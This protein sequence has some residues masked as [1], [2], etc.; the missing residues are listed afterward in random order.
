MAPPPTEPAGGRVVVLGVGEPYRRDDGCGPRVVRAVR[1]RVDASVTL[2]E[3]VADPTALLDLWDGAGL[4]VVVDA[5]RS[6]AVPGTVLRL[7]SSGLSRAALGRPTSSHGLSVR[8]AFEIGTALGKLP[9]RLVVFLV[10]AEDLGPGESVSPRVATGVA[11]AADRVAAEVN[12]FR[13]T[14]RDGR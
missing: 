6:G 4:A 11:E 7:E 10:E 14:A 2:V 13:R 12:A 5:M 8:D 3:H 9:R 1:G